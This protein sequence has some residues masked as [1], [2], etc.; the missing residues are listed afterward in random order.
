VD[1][2]G[3]LPNPTRNANMPEANEGINMQ[4]PGVETCLYAWHFQT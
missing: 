4:K 1:K 3:N 2:Q